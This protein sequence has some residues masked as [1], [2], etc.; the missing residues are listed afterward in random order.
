[1]IDIQSFM[2]VWT[3]T[4]SKRVQKRHCVGIPRR[5]VTVLL[6]VGALLGGYST[7]NSKQVDGV[8]YPFTGMRDTP[9]NLEKWGKVILAGNIKPT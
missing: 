3:S 5:W 9:D 2:W 1:M 4:R 6:V 7:L 8:G